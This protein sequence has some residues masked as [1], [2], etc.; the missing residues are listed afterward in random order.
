M[1]TQPK[2]T[3]STLYVLRM[4]ESFKFGHYSTS[5]NVGDVIEIR[6][7]HQPVYGRAKITKYLGHGEYQARRTE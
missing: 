2:A 1:N 7:Q 3:V 6:E 5:L 4:G